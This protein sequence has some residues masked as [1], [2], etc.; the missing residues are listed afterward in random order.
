[1]C[2][3]SRFFTPGAGQTECPN[4]HFRLVSNHG[5]LTFPFPCHRCRRRRRCCLSLSQFQSKDSSKNQQESGKN[6]A[7]ISK[8]QQES[9]KNHKNQRIKQVQDSEQARIK[10]QRRLKLLSSFC[11]V[12]CLFVCFVQLFICLFVCLVP[13][14]GGKK[15]PL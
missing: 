6:Q 4:S 15:R 12:V 3:V 11:S 1:L 13:H 10:A 7:R 8:N 9:S 14:Y 5:Y 2:F